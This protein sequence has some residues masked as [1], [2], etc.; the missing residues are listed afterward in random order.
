MILPV[1]TGS[2]RAF[3]IMY[4]IV[5]VVLNISCTSEVNAHVQP[6]FVT[7]GLLLVIG[8][9]LLITILFPGR[10]TSA[11][12]AYLGSNLTVLFLLTVIGNVNK[13]QYLIHLY[14][15]IVRK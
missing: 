10:H 5:K 1:D 4:T 8:P 6:H 7:I 9:V 14:I 2:E 12:H 11:E 15:K 13:R 3:L